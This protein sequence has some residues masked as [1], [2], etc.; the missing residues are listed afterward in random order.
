M[1]D[2]K[3][4]LSHTLEAMDNAMDNLK[5][6]NVGDPVNADAMLDAVDHRIGC[7]N[8]DGTI[9]YYDDFDAMIEHWHES[10]TFWDCVWHQH[11]GRWIKDAYWGL[12]HRTIDRYNIVHI[13]SLK[14]GYYDTDTR[15]LHSMFDLLVQFVEGEWARQQLDGMLYDGEIKLKWC[16]T[17]KHYLKVHKNEL[18]AAYMTWVKSLGPEEVALIDDKLEVVALYE[19]YR[20]LRPYRKDPTDLWVELKGAG[21]KE[22]M[23][24]SVELEAAQEADDTEHLIR[25]VKIRGRLW[26]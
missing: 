10:S 24:R 13:T 17:R 1:T 20:H 19:W 15:L 14:P 8:D 23:K 3:P 25:L 12:R 11:I 6:G 9:T 21:D 7:Q 2:D 4:L 22:A 18:L 26:T 16:E 5:Q